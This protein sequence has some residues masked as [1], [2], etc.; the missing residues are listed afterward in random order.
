MTGKADIPIPFFKPD[1]GEK[2]IAAVSSV[3]RSG[4]L[5]MGPKVLEFEKEFGE[6]VGA[7]HSVST[8]SCTSA[9][10]LSLIALGIGDGDEV[11]TT[12]FT[13]AATINSIIHCGAIPV[14]A[15]IVS[16]TC[17]MDAKHAVDLVTDRTKAILPV[18]FAGLSVDMDPLLKVGKEQGIMIVED[19]AHSI[20]ATYKNRHTGTLGNAGCF[21][22]YATKN[23]T[24][25]EG[26]MI[27][28][29]SAR[30]ADSLRQLRLHG[31]SHDSW[32]RYGPTGSWKYDVK[33]PG[34]KCNMTD[35]QAAIGL[36]QLDKLDRMNKRRAELAESYS[37][38]LKQLDG[39]I[40]PPLDEERVWHLYTIQLEDG[41]HARSKV[42]KRLTDHNIGFSVHFLSLHLQEA[43]SRLSYKKGDF[44]VSE[45]VSSSI[46]S[47][48]L[49]PQ[50][51][52]KQ[53][54]TVCHVIR[55]GL[56]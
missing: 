24:T 25:G 56:K 30:V 16:E 51:T 50:M 21:S 2:E 42:M 53:V 27:T 45:R 1:I 35:V 34:Y 23:L 48:P 3:L 55:M 11:I 18:H 38:H 31:L 19:C 9:L 49:F 14:F 43:Y 47:L 4:W 36:V 17:N 44:P 37:E 6:Y 46:I 10:F 20:G 7:S 22:F 41:D 29:N 39:I 15:D 26:G 52:M 54:E 13:F 28:S 8:S 32:K 12:P 40:I 5:T 33:V